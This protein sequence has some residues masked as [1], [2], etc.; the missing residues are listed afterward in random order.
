MNS[1]VKQLLLAVML[2]VGVAS[3]AG[4]LIASAHRQSDRLVVL[5]NPELI[6]ADMADVENIFGAAQNGFTVYAVKSSES[7][8]FAYN[9]ESKV[10]RA[11][12]LPQGMG[13]FTAPT[14]KNGNIVSSASPDDDALLNLLSPSRQLVRK[15]GKKKEFGIG[16]KKQNLFLNQGKVVVDPSNGVIYFVPTHSLMPSVQ[17]FSSQGELLAEFAVE[18]EAIDLQAGLTRKLL[19]NKKGD[20]AEGYTVITSAAVDPTTGHLWLSMNGS[21]KSGVV[22]EYSAKGKKLREYA[23]FLRGEAGSYKA[24]TGV[25]GLAVS[26]PHVFV[27]TVEGVVYRYSLGSDLAANLSAVQRVKERAERRDKTYLKQ[28]GGFV[29]SFWSARPSPWALLQ[30]SCPQEQALSCVT[31]CRPGAFPTT[32]NCGARAKNSMPTGTVIT[33]QTGCNNTGTVTG[34]ACMPTCVVSFNACRDNGDTFTSTYTSACNP[35]REICNNGVDEDCTGVADD[36]CTVSG[37]WCDLECFE[38]NPD[39]PCY[40]AWG[41]N[42]RPVEKTPK[43]VKAGYRAKPAPLC[44]CSSSPILID[45]LGNGFA[46]TSAAD[47]VKFD[48]N[49]D[50]VAKGHLSWTAGGADDAWLA[51]DRNG[52]GTVDSGAEL[53]GN[54]TPQPAP[55]EG[56]ERHGF[57]ALAEYDKAARGGNGDGVIDGR[58]AVHSSLRLWQDANHNGVSEPEELHTLPSLD[59]ASIELDYKES[60]QVDEHGNQFRYRGKVRDAKGAKINRWAWDVFLVPTP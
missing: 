4:L 33:G 6:F 16:D 1:R 3:S 32:T 20:C 58:D 59:V 47:G 37:V 26:S 52:N 7:R 27:L 55:P 31:N 17:K 54:A 53:F 25:K 44:Y 30:S 14:L 34:R 10:T 8:V 23:F 42:N 29:N 36:G 38:P 9:A 2:A 12:E 49:G 11:A 45:V 51:L 57:R 28:V 15:F 22:Y 50:G 18:G 40:G 48:F 13:S 41:R 5:H 35:P 43:F 56:A 39:C 60:K 19:E 21:S 24:I 46:M